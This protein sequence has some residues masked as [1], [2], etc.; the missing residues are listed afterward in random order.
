MTI[1]TETRDL[2]WRLLIY[3][4]TADKSSEPMESPTI[5]VYEKLRQSIGAFAGAA[6]FHSLA[7]RA[8]VL[9]R[10]EAPSL[11][12]A[13]IATDGSLRGFGGFEHQIDIE[14]EHADEDGAGERGAVLI[15]RLL[16]LLLVFL[17]EA[18]TFSLLRVA[19]PG[20]IFDD[21]NSGGGT[22]A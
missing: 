18:L 4:A 16:G 11:S 6:G 5:R 12:S 19:W 2:A 9:A 7:S 1:R 13:R 21:S 15:S 20:E 22:K 8:L 14:T 17:G 3:E 10:P